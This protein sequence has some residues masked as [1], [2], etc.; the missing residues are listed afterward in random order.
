MKKS[1]LLWL[2]AL[3]ALFLSPGRVTAGNGEK[4]EYF[5]LEN[6]ILNT[7]GDVV[8]T[9]TSVAKEVTPSDETSLIYTEQTVGPKGMFPNL[10]W[11]FPFDGKNIVKVTDLDGKLITTGKFTSRHNFWGWRFKFPKGPIARVS[12]HDLVFDK[13][14]SS[15]Y[16]KVV[17]RDGRKLTKQ[18]RV[19]KI[20]E[21]TYRTLLMANRR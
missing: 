21:S 19:I 11:V 5:L 7:D 9:S 8:E 14:L 2:L 6:R 15:Y 4:I 20:S 3:G 12:G 13:S 1:R 16:A 17:M 10:V 18:G